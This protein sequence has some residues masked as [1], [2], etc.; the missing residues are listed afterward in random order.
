M[1]LKTAKSIL[2]KHKPILEKRYH[3]KKIG[4]F[5]S[6][7]RG[8]NKKNSD[9][10]ILVEFRKSPGFEFITMERELKESMKTKI[11]LVSKDSLQNP[12]IKKHI[13]SEV[14]YI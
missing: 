8:E 2:K 11:D 10:D 13:L 14:V 9:I 12:I 4:I 6:I 1:D 3:I 7:V 5:G